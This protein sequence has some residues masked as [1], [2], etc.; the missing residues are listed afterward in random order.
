MARFGAIFIAICM[1]LIAGSV[2]A[3]VYLYFGLSGAES[4][5]V[6]LT[7]FTGLAVYNA[8]ATRLRDR[9]DVGTQIA[10]LSR[11]TA[12][13]AR[14]VLE[15][16][17]R[18]A[19]TEIRVESGIDKAAAVAKPLT[20]EIGEL[21]LL[22]K[23]L[24]ESI[25]AHD[26]ALA[27]L[28]P[29]DTATPAVPE[30]A[31]APVVP[32]ATAPIAAPYSA[33]PAAPAVAAAWAEAVPGA[34]APVMESAPVAAI[35]A[36]EPAAT[37]PPTPALADPPPESAKTSDRGVLGE[38][39]A[40]PVYVT[41]GPFRGMTADAIVALLR[42]AIDANRVD[43]YLQPIVTLP[44]RK[45]R[46]YEAMV[47]LR[48]ADGEM[49]A[50]ADFLPYAEGAGL[51]ARIDNLM[52]FRCV[53]VIRRL[54]AKKR[55]VG[56]FCNISASTLVDP[57]FFPQFLEFMG[58][59]RALA[60]SLVF[61]FMQSAMRTLGPI[62]N[63]SLGALNDH[64]FRFSMDNVTDLRIEPRDLAE[65]GIRFIKVPAALLLDR[66]SSVATDIH[67]ADLSS[68]LSR[69]G[70]ELVAEKIE[71]EG[72]VIDLLDFDVRYGQGHLFS[73]PRPVKPEVMQGIPDRA[74]APPREAERP[75]V[76]RLPA[77]PSAPAAAAPAEGL[78]AG[79]RISALVQ[80]ARGLAARG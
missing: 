41:K 50:P 2:G 68:L 32:A 76:P 18:V 19:A 64:G 48:T 25:A 40:A 35:V 43:L 66:R 37:V 23:Q 42:D 20:A 28:R 78:A 10:D 29:A 60:S 69:S 22:V 5:I 33:E 72:A 61:E 8:V 57:E 17:R 47:R 34:G 11:G 49:L 7:A 45:V 73:P 65:R 79:E 6:A 14:Q 70:I 46:Y 53:R 52:L 16:G 74:E 31:S 62:E 44:Q 39:E 63:E 36:S 58:A 59:N 12:D 56:V 38:A 80:L 21:G 1:V 15:L 4:W 13:L 9:S 67:P 3:L 26:A 54:L 51:M 55:D 27:A 30:P 24:A 77:A 71:T 75:A